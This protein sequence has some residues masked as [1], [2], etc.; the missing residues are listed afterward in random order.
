MAK[1]WRERH[2]FYQRAL[3]RL[4]SSLAPY[5]NLNDL[6]KDGAIQRFEFTFEL[7]WKTLQDYFIQ[8]SGYADVKGPRTVLKQVVS[9]N[10]IID[11]YT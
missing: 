3:K 2:E 1:R 8:E 4:T 7:A 5:P 11:G 9:D 6:K 10:L